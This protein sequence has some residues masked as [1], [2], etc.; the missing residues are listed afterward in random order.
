M[1]WNSRL[2]AMYQ[3]PE[4]KKKQN[5]KKKH[6]KI[7]A[8]G[9]KACATFYLSILFIACWFNSCRLQNTCCH[10]PFLLLRLWWNSST[11]DRV[12]HKSQ[13]HQHLYFRIRPSGIYGQLLYKC[14]PSYWFR[15]YNR[16]FGSTIS[17]YD[18]TRVKHAMTALQSC[19]KCLFLPCYFY[20]LRLVFLF[21]SF[22]FLS[23]SPPACM[24]V[25]A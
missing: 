8:K 23:C 6:D 19:Q 4:T 10:S 14:R 9:R 17:G 20:F 21:S 11:T 18:A 7:E 5:K 22:C 13:S 24:R 25:D 12:S 3:V 1:R 2:G 15:N 16:I